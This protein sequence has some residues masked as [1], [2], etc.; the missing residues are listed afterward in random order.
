MIRAIGMAAACVA[1]TFGMQASAD[2]VADFSKVEETWDVEIA[3][4]G[5]S[6]ALGC[7]VNARRSVCI[8]SLTDASAQPVIY[9]APDNANIIDFYWA[10]SDHV[11]MVAD[12]VITQRFSSGLEDLRVLRG[13]SYN[14]KKNKAA[15]LMRDRQG[16]TNTASVSS[17][18]EDKPNTV[19]MGRIFRREGA[20]TGSRLS[21]EDDGFIY[22][23]FDVNLNTGESR[24]RKR[25][26][27]S[28]VDIIWDRSGNVVAREIFND[29]RDTYSIRNADRK[30]VFEVK[31]AS[32]QPL[33]LRGM[34]DDETHFIAWS[35][36]VGDIARGTWQIPVEGGELSRVTLGDWTVGDHSAILDRYT[37]RV[38]GY[39]YTDD[40]SGQKFADPTLNRFQRI[41]SNTLPGA[42]VVIES[43][44]EDRSIFI[45]RAQ[46]PGRPIDY[47]LFEPAAGELSIIGSEQPALA[48]R[49]LGSI[50]SVEYAAADGLD[51]PG[52][53]TLPP[54]KTKADG[55]FPVVLMPH[56]GP[57]ASDTAAFDWWAQAYAA[58][59]YAVLQ[60]N[61]RG[62]NRYGQ[63]FREAGFGEFGG[64]MVTDTVDG[65][66]WLVAEGIGTPGGACI[67]GASYGGY[68]ALMAP[69]LRSAEIKCSISVN[70]VTD[71]MA[72]MGKHNNAG[73][74]TESVSYWEQYIGD[75]YQNAERR[76][77][78]TPAD[79]V[80]DYRTPVLLIHGDEDT[81][82]DFD[83][84]Q[85]FTAQAGNA[86]WLTSV[87]MEGEDHF[88]FTQNARRQV[89]ENSLA[90]LAEH[91]PAQAE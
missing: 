68:S 21:R 49:D 43:W 19:V 61:F 29:Q 45:V 86:S 18:L 59:G 74:Q 65:Y 27:S 50:L 14:P 89:L 17:M 87:V 25:F 62:S 83:Q 79:R 52:Y 12:M 44:T 28:E 73:R 7:V 55:P 46:K 60:P 3:P 84:Y 15:L 38:V 24:R 11:L 48:E 35:P 41:L 88:L 42:R 75:F 30:T 40:L 78:I 57:D 26:E 9:P 33:Y 66:T 54:G 10:S 53:L 71:P 91:H 70:G 69:L 37:N 2:I 90:F 80:N 58:A 5:N 39:W 81:R 32:I 34:S 85:G 77:A 1:A 64:K 6:V 82:V 13:I 22:V 76:A 47:Y 63:A 23:A 72:Q 4:D 36:G 31:D 67:A 20:R 8:Y 16:L 51:I 56:G